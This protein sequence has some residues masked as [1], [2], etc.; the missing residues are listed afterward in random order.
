M[1][2]LHS[3]LALTLCFFIAGTARV[4]VAGHDLEKMAKE[5]DT[6]SERFR[7][8]AAKHEKASSEKNLTPEQAQA[9]A[10][11]QK[12]L[13]GRADAHDHMAAALR[14]QDTRS[15]G[16]AKK[17]DQE[18]YEKLK[19]LWSR[20]N[21]RTAATGQDE[22][23]AWKDEKREERRE[24]KDPRQDEP[25]RRTDRVTSVQSEEDIQRWLSEDKPVADST[26][27]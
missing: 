12:L 1:K 4:A 6:A 3:A 11:M 16:E 19:Q 10:E 2:A 15:F 14:K 13:R 17:E 18:T 27:H 25:P 23:K 22:R 20:M 26:R 5:C 7:K 24:W 21:T 8:E 9:C